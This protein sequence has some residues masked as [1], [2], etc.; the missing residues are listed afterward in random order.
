[1]ATCEPCRT[2]PAVVVEGYEAKGKWVQVGKWRVCRSSLSFLSCFAS[3]S[4]LM[5][6]RCDVLFVGWI[7]RWFC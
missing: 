2:M 5:E 1:M 3:C 4:R 7:A 6:L